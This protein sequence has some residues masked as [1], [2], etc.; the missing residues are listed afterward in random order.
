MVLC[1][2]VKCCYNSGP[3]E[4]GNGQCGR[5]MPS[6]DENGVCKWLYMRGQVKPWALE[7][8]EDEYK[9]FCMVAEAIPAKEDNKDGEL[10]LVDSEVALERLGES[11]TDTDDSIAVN[12]EGETSSI[13]NA[14]L[15]GDG[16]E[17][18]IKE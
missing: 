13:E 18:Q 17:N 9:N 1:K 4:F 6:F 11:S 12:G 3:D 7:P 5:G 8:L 14:V 16:E 10:Y 15:D 2:C